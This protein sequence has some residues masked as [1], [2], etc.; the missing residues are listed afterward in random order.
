MLTC[1]ALLLA[2][3]PLSLAW[4]TDT[5]EYPWFDQYMN[6]E[7]YYMMPNGKKMPL[8]LKLHSHELVLTGTADLDQVKESFKDEYY[9][10]VS[11]GGK[12]SVQVWMN[13]FTDTDCGNADTKNPYLETRTSTWVTPKDSPLELPYAN[14]MSLLVADPKALIWI[15]RVILGDAPG[16][17][18]SKNDPALGALLGGHNVWGFPKHPV[19]AKIHTEYVGSDRVEF[20]AQHLA[21]NFLGQASFVDAIKASVKL[22]EMSKTNTPVPVNVKTAPDG[23]IGGPLY[24][25]QQV[26]FGEAF[27]TTQNI[28]PWDPTTDTFQIGHDD[29]YSSVLKAWKFEPKLK[30][31]T[32]D[33]Q[34]AAFKPSNWL[35]KAT[36][37][38]VVV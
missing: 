27:N 37:E 2:G 20:E 14:D 6:A 33:F 18:T 32:N 28:A 11:V 7:E 26:R 24:L 10:P 34:I 38:P 31:H 12:A 23:V 3:V 17:D 5:H 15:H 13:N 30:M 9:V 8:P 22:P 35:G 29:Y 16:I 21:K 25:V 1:A 4:D 36:A 19:K